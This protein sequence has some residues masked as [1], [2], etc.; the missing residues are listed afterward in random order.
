MGAREGA[1]VRPDAE[2]AVQSLFPQRARGEGADLGRQWL[3]HG[4]ELGGGEGADHRGVEVGAGAFVVV[5][6]EVIEDRGRAKS[7]HG[8]GV[9]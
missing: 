7:A 9:G 3:P 1:V 2:L 6:L 5:D 8:L 4:F